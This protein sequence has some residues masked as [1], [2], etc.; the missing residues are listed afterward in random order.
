MFRPEIFFYRFAGAI[1]SS[2]GSIYVEVDETIFLLLLLSA[3][4]TK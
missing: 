1:V 3:I 2:D 4:S